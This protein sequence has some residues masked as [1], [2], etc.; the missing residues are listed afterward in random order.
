MTEAKLSNDN[1]DTNK[2]FSCP[3]NSY[4]KMYDLRKF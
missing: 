3:Y 1:V 2:V 4:H